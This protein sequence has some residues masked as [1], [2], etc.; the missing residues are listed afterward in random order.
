MCENYRPFFYDIEE[1]KITPFDNFVDHEIYR[2]FRLE[3]SLIFLSITPILYFFILAVLEFK[4]IQKLLLLTKKVHEINYST[5]EQ[6]KLEKTAVAEKISELKGSMNIFILLFFFIV[7]YEATHRPLIR[8]HHRDYHLASKKVG[9][10]DRFI[11]LV[12]KV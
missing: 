6:V 12:S 8:T 3:N 11:R 5:D 2:Y 1:D 9:A 10:F 4:L 7:H